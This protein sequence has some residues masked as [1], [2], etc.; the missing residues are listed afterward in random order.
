MSTLPLLQ[1]FYRALERDIT[2]GLN[3]Q[4]FVHSSVAADSAT[5]LSDGPF[6]ECPDGYVQLITNVACKLEGTGSQYPRS[7]W[8]RMANDDFVALHYIAG[9]SAA[10]SITEWADSRVTDFLMFP[11]ETLTSLSVW[12]AGTTTNT[13]NCTV[14][15]YRF[16]KANFLKIAQFG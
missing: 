11:G 7:W 9:A 1:G 13:H 15:G 6:L 3:F 14:M 10:L 16:P 2:L 8:L 5:S 4:R 12:N